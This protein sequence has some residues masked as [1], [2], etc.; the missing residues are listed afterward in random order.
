MWK[1]WEFGFTINCGAGVDDL[2]HEC[3]VLFLFLAS[4]DDDYCEFGSELRGKQQH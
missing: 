4:F 3:C 2:E 1:N